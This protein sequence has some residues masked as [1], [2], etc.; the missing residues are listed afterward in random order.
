L[1]TG[2]LNTAQGSPAC[3][4]MRALMD[5]AHYSAIH[6][7]EPTMHNSHGFCNHS[8]EQTICGDYA[9]SNRH[10]RMPRGEII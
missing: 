2:D 4:E 8:P 6:R 3:L 1:Q 5:C 9:I 10:V 7:A